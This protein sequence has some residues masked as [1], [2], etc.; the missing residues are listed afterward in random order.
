MKQ[1][2]PKTSAAVPG[3]EN[4]VP[5]TSGS[6]TDNAPLSFENDTNVHSQSITV[7]GTHIDAQTVINSD[8]KDDLQQPSCDSELSNLSHENYG[9]YHINGTSNA[10]YIT[11]EINGFS[12]LALVDTGAD[13]SLISSETCDS[14]GL[15]IIPQKSSHDVVG[16]SNSELLGIVKCGIHISGDRTFNT[17][18]R[19]FPSHKNRSNKL[20]LGADFFDDNNFEVVMANK[21]L[22]EY[23]NDESELHYYFD[24]SGHLED[25]I[26]INIP[27]YAPNELTLSPDTMNV[28]KLDCVIPETSKQML[29]TSHISDT[30]VNGINGIM[31][32]DTKTVLFRNR[33]ETTTIHKG[34]V[35]GTVS[36]ILEVPECDSENDTK[37]EFS[38]QDAV[39]LPELNVEDADR[40]RRMLESDTIKGVFSTG[41]NDVGLAD[42]IPHKIIL[43]DATPVYQR[44]RRFPPPI[45]REMDEQCQVLLDLGVIEHSSSPWSS[46]LVPVRKKDG[47]LRLCVDYRRLNAL[48]VADKFPLPNLSDSIYSLHGTQY[49]TRLDLV[50][51]YHQ[52]P[53]CRVA[54]ADGVFNTN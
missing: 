52:I 39:K 2:E 46:P 53:R 25:T 19:V 54:R 1:H 24:E 16:E 17:N 7:Q 34:Q 13:I 5:S 45:T 21:L 4:P 12:V 20:L 48:T 26:Y 22:I 11:V 31:N 30:G 43:H 36:S 47:G 41:E 28:V 51:A 37:L 9:I 44:P 18:L 27:C 40:V 6:V 23:R 3:L 29:F 50:K 14:L 33:D 15:S 35:L 42:V 32:R 10:F 38:I 49:F 8:L